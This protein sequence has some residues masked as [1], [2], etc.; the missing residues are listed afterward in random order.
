MEHNVGGLGWRTRRERARLTYSTTH[1]S[2]KGFDQKRSGLRQTRA[3][4]ATFV[5]VH[6]IEGGV[7]H[8]E[9]LSRFVTFHTLLA[10]VES[11]YSVVSFT[12][13]ELANS[14]AAT[15][16]ESQGSGATTHR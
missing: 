5:G 16:E 6:S 14:A 9:W 11:G 7:A 10:P 15:V 3:A 4:D 8:G 13:P 2:S 1:A 12:V